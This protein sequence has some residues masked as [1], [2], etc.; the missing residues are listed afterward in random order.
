[1]NAPL[2]TSKLAREASDASR[3]LS[4]KVMQSAHE[5]VETTRDYANHALNQADSKLRH[6]R[7]M[8]DPAIEEFASSAQRLARRG[9]DIAADTSARAQQSLNRYAA[10]T[11][12][13]VADQPV[14]AVL[15]AAAAGAVIAALLLSARKRRERDQY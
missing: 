9:I 11:E 14:K 15:I 1:M 2:N 4:D 8:V 7:G 10:V 13:Y 5:A 12:R 3:Q 6:V